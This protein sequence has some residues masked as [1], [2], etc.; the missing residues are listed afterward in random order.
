MLLLPFLPFFWVDLIWSDQN[1]FSVWENF[2]VFSFRGS[3]NSEAFEMV[4]I[5]SG[6]ITVSICSDLWSQR[7][8]WTWNCEACNQVTAAAAAQSLQSCPTLCDPRDGSPPGS[9]I[10]GVLQARTL[11]LVAISFSNAWKWK[12]SRSVSVQ[13]FVTPLKSI[14][15]SLSCE[16]SAAADWTGGRSLMW[17]QPAHWLGANNVAIGRKVNWA[18]QFLFVNWEMQRMKPANQKCIHVYHRAWKEIDASVS[19]LLKGTLNTFEVLP[20]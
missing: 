9:P 12:W 3:V 15:E 16:P 19:L 20:N 18:P 2:S 7:S 17:R 13:L 11:E 5:P 4:E 1:I 8:L 6:I 14:L 10:P